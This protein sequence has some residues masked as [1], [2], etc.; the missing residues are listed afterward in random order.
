M[1]PTEYTLAVLVTDTW[2]CFKLQIVWSKITNVEAL[3]THIYNYIEEPYFLKSQY[4][5]G[6][7]IMAEWSSESGN[8]RT[9]KFR[10]ATPRTAYAAVQSAN[11]RFMHLYIS[12]SFYCWLPGWSVIEFSL[13]LTD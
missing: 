4:Q 1:A 3:A 13:D 11:S 10:S 7:M 6:A 5:T 8:R 9:D 12:R 2:H